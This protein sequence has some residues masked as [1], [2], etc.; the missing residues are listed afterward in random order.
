[1]ILITSFLPCTCC[2]YTQLGCNVFVCDDIYD[3][4]AFS[5]SY[6][7]QR[8]CVV[9]TA[10]HISLVPSRDHLYC[11]HGLGHYLGD[12]C[13]L[14]VPLQ[15]LTPH[16]THPKRSFLMPPSDPKPVPIRSPFT[17]TFGASLTSDAGPQRPGPDQRSGPEGFDCGRRLASCGAALA[18]KAI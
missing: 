3:L 13:H 7:V 4:A 1:M 18:A 6:R 14:T 2:P 12:R 11:Q 8:L 17:F 5:I 15:S 16:T 10:T 9:Q